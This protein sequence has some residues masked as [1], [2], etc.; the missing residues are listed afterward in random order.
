MAQQM[1]EPVVNIAFHSDTI[2]WLMLLAFD[3]PSSDYLANNSFICLYNQQN[4]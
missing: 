3:A 1:A 2:A 4:S